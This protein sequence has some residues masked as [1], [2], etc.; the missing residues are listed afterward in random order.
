MITKESYHIIDTLIRQ[1]RSFALWRIPG[2]ETIHFRMQSYGTPDLLHEF[3][4]LNG[5]SVLHIRQTS[6]CA[7][8]TGLYGFARGHIGN[9]A[10]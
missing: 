6:Y 4:E 3:T 8:P 9:S 1:G 7:D 10:R 5:R 2:N